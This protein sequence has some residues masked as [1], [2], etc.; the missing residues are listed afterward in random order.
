MEHFESY[1]TRRDVDYIKSL[2]LD[3][4]RMGFDQVVVEEAPGVYRE[5]IFEI[6]ERFIGWCR[7]AGLNLVLNMH[8]AIGNY[9]DIQEKVQLLDSEELQERFIA[10]WLEFEKRF[11]GHPEVAF[12]LLNEVRNVDPEKWNVLAKKT[13]AEIRKLNPNRLII[14]GSTCWTD[15]GQILVRKCHEAG[16]PVTALPGPCAFVTALAL[17]G[18]DSRRFSF[19][20]F[21]PTDKKER[22]EVLEALKTA[23]GTT[24]FYEAPHRL[25]DTLK[26]LRKSSGLRPAACVREISKKFEEIRLGT[27]PE[28]QAWFEENEPRGE[29]V[30]LIE[31]VSDEV[32]QKQKAERFEDMSM[33][34]HMA[35]YKDLPEKEAM[36]AVAKDRGISKRD[37]YA[38]LKK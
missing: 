29:F 17:S 28:L 4:I 1:I 20:G 31:G 22:E 8:K 33:E 37:V 15:P 18:L 6:I 26:L 12:E 2:G 13:I 21:L 36:K 19:E 3:H 25:K 32:R 23:R 11:H 16:I 27:I 5:R 38:A 10:V 30:I 34:E 7:D 35:L 14:I 24:I 9:C